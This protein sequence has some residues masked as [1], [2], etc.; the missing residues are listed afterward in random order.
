MVKE[1]ES[2]HALYSPFFRTAQQRTASYH[3]LAGL[4]D[5]EIKRKSVENIALARVGM[6]GVRPLQT[7]VGVSQWADGAILAEHRRQTG[8]TF[9]RPTGV[10]MIDGSDCAKQGAYSVGVQRQW[11]GELGK[12]ANCQAGV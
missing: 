5:P 2:Y 8:F 7:F 10:I 6:A 4:L 11:C 3:Y 9:G 12:Q 1:L